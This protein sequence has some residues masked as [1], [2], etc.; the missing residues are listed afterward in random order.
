[1]RNKFLVL[2]SQYENMASSEAIHDSSI[3]YDGTS[4]RSRASSVFSTGTKFSVATLQQEELQSFTP[5]NS[6][7]TARN[8]TRPLSLRTVASHEGPAPPY[9]VYQTSEAPQPSPAQRRFAT[10]DHSPSLAAAA[11]ETPSTSPA[12]EPEN[13]LSMHYGRVVRTIDQNHARELANLA[14]EHERERAYLV[15]EH[16]RALAAVRHEIDQAYRKEWKV[17]NRE[18]EKF[19]EEANARVASLEVECKDLAIA[20]AAIVAQLQQDA[21]DQVSALVE[22]H[23]LAIDKAR[24][25]IED[26][27]EGRWSDRDRLAAEEARRLASENQLRLE[28]AVAD[29]DLE[30]RFKLIKAEADRDAAVADRDAA[31]A[32]RDAVVADRDTVVADRD[33]VV[34]DRD[35]VVADRDAVVADRDAAVAARDAEWIKELGKR[36]PEFLHELKD[37]MNELSVG[38]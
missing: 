37:I 31:L 23:V 20:H 12:S 25:A 28:K 35:A 16:E 18:V 22:E 1:M 32:D 17:K 4:T 34:A 10:T 9:E 5:G 33:A 27:W 14:R 29:R 21:S 7:L 11:L 13:A 30:N 38:N 24:N 8:A 26:I 6:G 19:R 2:R 15:T 3:D 36:H